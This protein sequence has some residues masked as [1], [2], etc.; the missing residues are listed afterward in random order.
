MSWP[1]S[2]P[3]SSMSC[4]DASER[5][6]SPTTPEPKDVQAYQQLMTSLFPPSSLPPPPTQTTATLPENNGDDEDEV[7]EDGVK[8]PMT[9]AEKQNAKKKRRKERERLAKMEE[10][11][12]VQTAAGVGNSTS[13]ELEPLVKFRLFSACPVQ[14]VLITPDLKDERYSCPVNPRHLPIP[15]ETSQRI[16]H[17]ANEA[18]IDPE[19]LYQSSSSSAAT[20]QPDKTY[21]TDTT[22][23]NPLPPIFIGTISRSRSISTHDTRNNSSISIPNIQITVSQGHLKSTEKIR[24]KTRRSKHKKTPAQA[25]F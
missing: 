24:Q 14:D 20:E 16:H 5:P 18:A 10:E 6:S 13:N 9:K 7:V 8:R 21:S 15:A 3:A 19:G 1:S 25:R 17:I 22:D 23:I 4:S 2:S 12:K 11:A